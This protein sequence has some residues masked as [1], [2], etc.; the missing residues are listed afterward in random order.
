MFS[1]GLNR[2]IYNTLYNYNLLKQVYK[3]FNNYTLFWVLDE[4][5]IL[6]PWQTKFD[7]GLNK[8]KGVVKFWIQNFAII[9]TI[10]QQKSLINVYFNLNK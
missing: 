4:S 5:I 7:R 9:R 8:Q 3:F 2:A 10:Q 6:N 1:I